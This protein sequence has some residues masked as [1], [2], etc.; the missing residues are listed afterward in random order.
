M[1]DLYEVR[2]RTSMHA[3]ACKMGNSICSPTAEV[4]PS[5]NT[6]GPGS[7]SFSDLKYGALIG[8]LLH[9]IDR[10]IDVFDS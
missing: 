5:A 10:C 8:W 6:H 3:M 1:V 4:E 9:D 2:M 7:V